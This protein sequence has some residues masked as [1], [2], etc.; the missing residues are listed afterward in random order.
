MKPRGSRGR[1]AAQ[2]EV[3]DRAGAG[4]WGTRRAGVA[5]G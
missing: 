2:A 4:L 1:G 5:E 3:K